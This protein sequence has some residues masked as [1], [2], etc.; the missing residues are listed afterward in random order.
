ML[1]TAYWAGRAGSDGVY[2]LCRRSASDREGRPLLGASVLSV[3]KSTFDAN[4][5]VLK[6]SGKKMSKF[7]H[8]TTKARRGQMGEFELVTQVN[9]TSLWSVHSRDGNY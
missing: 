7:L 5:T 9:L 2:G 6:K 3:R 4:F 8:G 1:S